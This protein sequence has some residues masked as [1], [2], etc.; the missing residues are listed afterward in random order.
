[1]KYIIYIS[2]EC[3]STLHVGSMIIVHHVDFDPPS[4]SNA[5]IMARWSPPI[6]MLDWLNRVN[7]ETP[8]DNHGFPMSF[9]AGVSLLLVTTIKNIDL[10]AQESEKIYI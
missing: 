10:P 7:A 1:M 5:H 3:C 8:M 4:S 9:L 2:Q 6:C